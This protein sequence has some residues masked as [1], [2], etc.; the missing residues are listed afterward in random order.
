M[1][2]S[3]LEARAAHP[4]DLRF[5]PHAESEIRRAM[6]RIDSSAVTVCRFATEASGAWHAFC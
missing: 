6:R 3:L 1:P 5:P 2:S 4:A